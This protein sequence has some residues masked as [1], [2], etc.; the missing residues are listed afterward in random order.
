MFLDG[1]APERL[2]ALVR[3]KV[4]DRR[5][6]Q[7][8]ERYLYQEVL[9]GLD[10]WRPET[11]TTQGA[12]LSPLLA[13]IYLDPLDHLLADS[14][15]EMVRYADDF[16]ILCRTEAAAHRAPALVQAWT[17]EA[18]LTLHPTKTRLLDA[19]QRGGF[20]FLGYH[21][22]R[23]MHC[24]RRRRLERACASACVRSRA[25]PRRTN[26][27]S[28]DCIVAR[29]NP[30]LRGWFTY[31]QHGRPY[32]LPQLDS[33]LRMRLRA[34]QRQRQKHKGRGRRR[35]RQRW[36]NAFSAELGLFSMAA[37]HAQA[38]QSARR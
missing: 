25:R 38:C 18:R 27:H 36:P 17:A 22:A 33:W 35:D 11:G 9:D 30:V 26:G 32:D 6:L 29:L 2:L 24:G 12:V 31:F 7:L 3:R 4:A 20:D 16:V 14:G 10:R 1:L 21:F 19:S 23:G 15:Y 34:L 8:L 13:N 28:L 5:V 37:A